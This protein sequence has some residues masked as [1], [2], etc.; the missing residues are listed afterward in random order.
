MCKVWYVQSMVCS[1][2]LK[3]MKVCAKS[4]YGISHMDTLSHSQAFSIYEDILIIIAVP[5]EPNSP[6]HSAPAP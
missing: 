5:I 6:S 3:G 4:Q 1:Y 2:T